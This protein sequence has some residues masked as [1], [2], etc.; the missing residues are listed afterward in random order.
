MNCSQ[1]IQNW[2]NKYTN[3]NNEDPNV[4]L[5]EIG[6]RVVD[7]D[8]EKRGKND[9]NQ[10]VSRKSS[11][12]KR[13][14]EF[15]ST[16]YNQNGDLPIIQITT[17]VTEYS[18]RGCGIFGMNKQVGIESTNTETKVRTK[19]EKEVKSPS[20]K[21]SKKEIKHNKVRDG[22]KN[23]RS[24]GERYDEEHDNPYEF[25]N[26]NGE[27]NDEPSHYSEMLYHS[28]SSDNIVNKSQQAKRLFCTVLRIVIFRRD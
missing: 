7:K 19:K 21:N 9:F 17:K 20:R 27:C 16:K 1:S 8:K 2:N 18:F 15:R 14:T 25:I 12:R 22:N 28:V 4:D 5:E 6:L 10:S 11:K 24:S 13:K 23:R 26:N 3:N